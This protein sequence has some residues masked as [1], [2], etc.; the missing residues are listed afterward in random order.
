MDYHTHPTFP[1]L[2]FLKFDGDYKCLSKEKIVVARECNGL[3]L[4]AS[5]DWRVVSMPYYKISF[6][7]S[8][9]SLF[10]FIYFLS[11]FY[12]SFCLISIFLSFI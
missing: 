10:L 3:I 12:Y 2:V 7:L 9:A 8:F 6:F 5:S 4:D 1:E 11:F